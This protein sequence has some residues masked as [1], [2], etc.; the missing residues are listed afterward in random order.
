MA[1]VINSMRNII[2]D[3]LWV[4]KILFC[5]Y[6]VFLFLLNFGYLLKHPIA[7]LALLFVMFFVFL[8]SAGILMHRNINNLSPI[9]PDIRD[10]RELV[11][12][13]LQLGLIMAPFVFL[14]VLVNGIV[15][16]NI[17]QEQP[18]NTIF[19]IVVLLMFLPFIF[20]P[21]VLFSAKKRL[22][23]AYRFDLLLF[24]GGNFIVSVLSYVLQFI[25][26]ILSFSV[27]IHIAL[28]NMFGTEN[29]TVVMWDAIFLTI[30]FFSIFS[31][32]ADLYDDVIP[33]IKRKK[34]KV[35]EENL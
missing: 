2:S 27:F 31:Y 8:G 24:S 30:T 26:I 15:Q 17:V 1:S 11:L 7:M 20:V 33:L 13:A 16:A 4:P 32:L 34:K 19:F 10:F 25:L 3:S 9:L 18:V 6:L 22:I 23:D 35:K 12:T 5:S 14:Y 21:T 29:G 28:I